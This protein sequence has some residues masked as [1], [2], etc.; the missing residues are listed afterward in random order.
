MAEEDDVS[1]L[2]SERRTRKKYIDPELEKRG[3]LKKLH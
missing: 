1:L 3:W 2:I